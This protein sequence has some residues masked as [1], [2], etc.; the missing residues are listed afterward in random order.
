MSS[1]FDFTVTP[2]FLENV[3]VKPYFNTQ[4][5]GITSH[6]LGLLCWSRPQFEVSQVGPQVSIL[7]RL[8]IKHL[9]WYFKLENLKNQ[10]QI[11]RYFVDPVFVRSYFF[12]DEPLTIWTFLSSQSGEKSVQTSQR[13][14]CKEV[15]SYKIHTSI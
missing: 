8:K 4:Q 12:T 2:W 6:K 1:D 7:N 11:D 14:T 10:V 15:I 13:F 3:W 5:A 9:H